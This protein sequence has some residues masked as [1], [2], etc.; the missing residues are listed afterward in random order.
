MQH[1]ENEVIEM[2]RTIMLVIKER[3]ENHKLNEENFKML[4]PDTLQVSFSFIKTILSKYR[5]KVGHRIDGCIV[6]IENSEGSTNGNFVTPRKRIDLEKMK[7][8]QGEQKLL[9]LRINVSIW[10]RLDSMMKNNPGVQKSYLLSYIL[11]DILTQF[12]S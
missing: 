9:S 3:S 6:Q 11:D 5:Y 7:Q 12:G 4:K 1:Q 10:D 8:L 2:L